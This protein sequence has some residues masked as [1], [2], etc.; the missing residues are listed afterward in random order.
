[1]CF[2]FWVYTFT[3][4]FKKGSDWFIYILWRMQ[5]EGTVTSK[6]GKNAQNSQLDRKSGELRQGN[7]SVDVSRMHKNLGVD[8]AQQAEF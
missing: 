7:L 8:F 5:T 6:D 3:A 2:N 1:M 4:A